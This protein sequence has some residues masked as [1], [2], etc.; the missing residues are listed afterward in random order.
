MGLKAR[1]PQWIMQIIINFIDKLLG[2]SGV[3][4]V[5]PDLNFIKKNIPSSVLPNVDDIVYF[6]NE[7]YEVARVMHNFE[8]YRHNILVVII[9]KPKNIVAEGTIKFNK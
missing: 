9:P 8:N 4:L 2:R 3:H 7:A 1:K 6:S 5:D